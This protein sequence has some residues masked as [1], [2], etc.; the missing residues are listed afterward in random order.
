[1]HEYHQVEK[2]VQDLLSQY[3]GCKIKSVQLVMGDLLGFDESSVRLYFENFTENTLAE[4][5]EVNL[6]WVKSELH[7]DRCAKNFIKQGSDL[8]CPTCGLQG[9]PTTVGKEFY[10]DEVVIE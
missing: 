7:C 8:N 2:L 1:M 5:A 4:G 3:P 10:L 6:R 9:T